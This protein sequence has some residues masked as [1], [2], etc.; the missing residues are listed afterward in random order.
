MLAESMDSL[1]MV[2]P[3]HE[4]IAPAARVA[5]LHAELADA[6]ARSNDLWR[7]Y[8]DERGPAMTA[9]ILMIV[10]VRSR[11]DALRPLYFAAQDAH[12]RW[13]ETTRELETTDARCRD[14]ARAAAAATKDGRDDDAL[15]AQADLALV[16]ILR[17]HAHATERDAHQLWQR[18][19]ADLETAAGGPGNIVTTADADVIRDTA[20]SID[21]MSVDAPAPP[22]AH[23]KA[24]SCARKCT[25]PT[26]MP[27]PSP[28][29]P[30][31]RR[32]A[33]PS[34]TVAARSPSSPSPTSTV[35]AP[36]P[37]RKSLRRIAVHRLDPTAPQRALL[38]RIQ[39]S[40]RSSLP[41]SPCTHHRVR[42][43]GTPGIRSVGDARLRA[44]PARDIASRRE[45]PTG[46]EQCQH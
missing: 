34:R 30:P 8:L 45:R 40:R 7:A 13:L 10:D 2:R 9:A 29:T 3:E 26:T 6:R 41:R 44:G 14:L 11:A 1:R 38:C 31:C 16:E 21:Q 23:S 36:P 4:D 19:Q 18:A 28:N 33:R 39:R 25:R 42:R 12:A 27:P 37:H 5:A 35:Q 15:H 17:E 20:A 24:R 32:H 43:F 22:F 46:A